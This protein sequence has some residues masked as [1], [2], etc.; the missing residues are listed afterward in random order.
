MKELNLDNFI[1]Y[2]PSLT[3]EAVEKEVILRHYAFYHENKTQTAAALGIT[4]RTLYDKLEKYAEDE[5]EEEKRRAEKQR[6]TDEFIRRSRGSIGAPYYSPTD[7]ARVDE[8]RPRIRMEPAESA[9]AK[10]GVPLPQ[11]EEVQ[12]V[13]PEPASRGGT[14]KRSGRA[15]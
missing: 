5:K 2:S 14:G 1:P 10:Q 9:P 13:L 15:S 8:T 6:Q 3:L 7:P 4:A 12:G 11:R